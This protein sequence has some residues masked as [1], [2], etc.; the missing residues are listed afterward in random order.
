[1]SIPVRSIKSTKSLMDSVMHEAMKEPEHPKI[2]Y[3][4][5]ELTVKEAPAAAGAPI[6]LDAKGELTVAGVTKSIEMPVNLQRQEKGI[7]KFGGTTALKMSDFGIKPPAP[8][9]A[10]GAIKTG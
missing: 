1:I 3:K 8:A 9:L 7:L 4:L 2:S 10:L 6:K 5:T